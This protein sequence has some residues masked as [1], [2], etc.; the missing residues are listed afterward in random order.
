[1]VREVSSGFGAEWRGRGE[2]QNGPIDSTVSSLVSPRMLSFLQEER[3]G[4]E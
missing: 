4:M 2:V 3:K 1:M